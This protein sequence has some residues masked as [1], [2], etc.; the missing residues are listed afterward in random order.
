MSTHRRSRRLESHSRIYSA[1]AVDTN[2]FEDADAVIMPS[3]CQQLQFS[4]I[5]NFR[6]EQRIFRLSRETSVRVHLSRSHSSGGPK[7]FARFDQ[8]AINQALG[9]GLSLAFG[10]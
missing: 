2:V 6:S 7:D 3:W 4:L 1:V 8:S 5:D 9:I 10:G